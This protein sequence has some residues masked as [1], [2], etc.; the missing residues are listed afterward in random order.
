[1]SLLPL[2][3]ACLASC[4]ALK[5]PE[6]AVTLR[7]SP[8]FATG[9]APLSDRSFSV[10][11]VLARGL[12]AR[13]RYL[14]FAE[15]NPAEIHQAATLFWEEPP[16]QIIERGIVAGLRSRYAL[17][18]GPG[19]PVS[20]DWRV[21]VTVTRFEEISGAHSSAEVSLDAQLLHA[22]KLERSGTFCGHAPIGDASPESRAQAF[23]A[24]IEQAVGALVQDTAAAPGSPSAG[25]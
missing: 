24:A 10:A 13:T 12:V 9:A 14:Y 21:L 25:C 19:V 22:G 1:M 3:A 11:P 23:D 17:V 5:G 6:A 15:G 8:E 16:A 18:S 7:L 2:L 4:V 20:A